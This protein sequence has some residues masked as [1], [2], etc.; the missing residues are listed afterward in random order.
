MPGCHGGA[1]PARGMRLD[2]AGIYSSTVNV[3]ARTDERFLRVAPGAP[4]HSLLYL[5]LLSPHQGGYRGPRMPLSMDPLKED[6]VALVKAWIEAFPAET[7]GRP[8]EAEPEAVP[9]RG[10]QDAYLANLPTSDS[11]GARTLEF[12]FVHR[13]KASAVD[14]G[15]KGL[16][17]LD[18]GAW[19]S[20]D[21]AYGLTNFLDVGLRRTN[22][23]TD[24]EGYAKGVLIRQA[25]GGSPLALSARG[26]VSSVRETDRFHRTRWGAQ[27]IVS[28]RFGDR[29][30][31]MLVPTY[32]THTDD[33]NPQDPRGTEALGGGVEWHLDPR[34]AVTG[35]W[36]VQVSGVEAPF[37]S[38]S[39]GFS[40][41]T[42]RHVFHLLVTNTSGH[43]TDLVAPG[44][45]LDAGAGRFRFGFN[46]SR[47]HAF[48][49][50]QAAPA[51]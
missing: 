25:P 43:Q 20:L 35:E 12:R 2:A 13:F 33:L 44:G 29:L 21:L 6:E 38:A 46:I 3:R 16:Y 23:E 1:R 17:G 31:A 15:S 48:L 28:R 51:P 27:L 19:V 18:S 11:I 45:D 4:D 24:Y 32:V 47:T 10:F 22:L 26:S 49:P 42:A 50:S 7:W 9:P 30:S 34:Y 40:A 41:A 39:L 36:I 37:Q 14:A 5:K 8:A